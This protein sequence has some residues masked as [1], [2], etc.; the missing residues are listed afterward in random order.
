MQ[1]RR[2]YHS[3][4]AVALAAGLLIVS[5]SNDKTSGTTTTS[6]A[7]TNGATTSTSSPLT[8]APLKVGLL[9]PAPADRLST[10]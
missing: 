4:A 1:A 2:P 3:V 10:V 8:G 5:C 7:P 9:A 6:G